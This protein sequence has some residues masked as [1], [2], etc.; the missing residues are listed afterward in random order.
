MK[1]HNNWRIIIVCNIAE[2]FVSSVHSCSIVSSTPNNKITFKCWQTKENPCCS[3]YSVVV[4]QK[5]LDRI[6]RI[7]AFN[8]NN[9]KIGTSE[10]FPNFLVNPYVPLPISP[11]QWHLHTY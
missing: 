8:N 5:L 2:A 1:F 4:L 6:F 9:N 3:A 11:F 7:I 10:V